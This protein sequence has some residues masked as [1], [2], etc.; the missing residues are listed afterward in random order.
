MKLTDLPKL[1]YMPILE[2][3][4]EDI[5][6]RWVNRA[7]ELAKERGLPPPPTGE[8]EYFYDLWYPIAQE[9]AE[10]QELWTYGF[11][12][13][14]PIWAD[15][16]F[17]EAH[18][19]ADGLLRK[20][21][22][23]DDTFR[24]RLL[25]RAFIEEGSGRRKDYELWAKEVPGVGGVIAVEKERHDNSIDLYLTDMNGNP[26][27]PEFAEQVKNLMWE[28]KRIAGHDLAAYPA[29]VFVL[30]IEAALEATGDRTA[31][32]EQ[33]KKRVLAYAEGRTKLVYNYVAALLVF[34]IG[35]NYSNFTMNGETNDIEIPPVSLLQVEVN[36]L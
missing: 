12:Q 31:L 24:L 19:W 29:P 11:I 25:D 8:G 22:E 18:G 36:L 26:V 16:E 1:P 14:F 30:R 10:Q 23:D 6:Q 32:A 7:I 13:A 20:E 27:T 15:G 17:L 35:E 33:I 2:E 34:D 9:Y 21:G 4:P 28:D 5:Y 3:T